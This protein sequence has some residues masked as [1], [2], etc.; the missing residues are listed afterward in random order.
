[1]LLIQIVR[2]F[3]GSHHIP[4]EIGH[5]RRRVARHL[6]C[7]LDRVIQCGK[8]HPTLDP[9]LIQGA[10]FDKR[11]ERPAIHLARVSPSAQVKK[12]AE[13]PFLASGQ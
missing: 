13:R 10:A 2:R 12:T 4:E 5:P 8:H 11:F 7:G 3:A 9:Q 6:F 1:M